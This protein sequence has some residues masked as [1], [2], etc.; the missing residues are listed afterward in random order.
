MAPA[1]DELGEVQQP[2]PVDLK[3]NAVGLSAAFERNPTLLDEPDSQQRSFDRMLPEDLS[4]G[5]A[6]E[7]RSSAI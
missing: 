2:Q 4:V 7:H 6:I 5:L 3:A 1:D